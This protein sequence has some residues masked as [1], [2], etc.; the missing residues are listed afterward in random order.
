MAERVKCLPCKLG[1]LSLIPG[2]HLEKL[3][4]V[5]YPVMPELQRQRY[6]DPWGPLTSQPSL[7]DNLQAI[8]RYSQNIRWISLEEQHSRL[9][10][11][12]KTQANKCTHRTALTRKHENTDHR[13][14]ETCIHVKA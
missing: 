3:S 11:G 1:D 2:T 5:V 10:S 12:L 7:L 6:M 14:K 13:H 4:M 8:E 9:T